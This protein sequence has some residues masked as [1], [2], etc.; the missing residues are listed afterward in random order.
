MTVHKLSFSSVETQT[1]IDMTLS[2]CH[3]SAMQIS[4]GWSQILQIFFFHLE[5]NLLQLS[6]V[7]LLIH[8]SEVTEVFIFCKSN[9]HFSSYFYIP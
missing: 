8:S 3:L 2:K 6:S 1:R 7:H 4:S 9:A 5:L